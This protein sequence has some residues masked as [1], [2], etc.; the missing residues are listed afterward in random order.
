MEQQINGLQEQIDRQ[1]RELDPEQLERFKDLRQENSHLVSEISSF[2][3]MLEELTLESSRLED[4]TF[5]I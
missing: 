3:A 4:V 1:I 2:Q 5:F